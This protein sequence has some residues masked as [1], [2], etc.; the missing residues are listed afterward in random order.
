MKPVLLRRA[1][2]GKGLTSH[3]RS[4]AIRALRPHFFS[5]IRVDSTKVCILFGYM[6]VWCRIVLYRTLPRLSLACAC[7]FWSSMGDSRL[8]VQ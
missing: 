5:Q 1:G 2:A 7:I 3:Q 4:P 6:D 8:F